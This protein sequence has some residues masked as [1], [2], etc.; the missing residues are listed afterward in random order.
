MRSY[1]IDLDKI[2][3]GLHSQFIETNTI[4][5]QKRDD[6]KTRF[7]GTM[8]PRQYPISQTKKEVQI[9]V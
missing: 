8:L 2:I 3:P 5:K 1:Q 9:L 7:D 4:F 6:A